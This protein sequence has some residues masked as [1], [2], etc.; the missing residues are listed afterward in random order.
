M[1]PVSSIVSWP[2][3]LPCVDGFDRFEGGSVSLACFSFLPCAVVWW[4]L[5]LR[6]PRKKRHHRLSVPSPAAGAPEGRRL[7][8]RALVF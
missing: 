4:L 8:S 3:F 2:A 6:P 5:L 7:W 1:S